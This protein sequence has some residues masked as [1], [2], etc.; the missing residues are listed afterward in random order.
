MVCPN[1]GKQCVDQA[2]KCPKCGAALTPQSQPINN[3]QPA[4]AGAYPAAKKKKLPVWAIVL[5]VIGA[6]VIV[7]VIG[8]L[9]NGGDSGKQ[10]TSPTAQDKVESKDDDKKDDEKVSSEESKPQESKEDYIKSAKEIA[11]KDLAREP[12]QYKGQRIKITVQIS[13][14]ISGGLFTSGGYRCYEDYDLGKGDTWLKK[15]WFVD[16]KLPEGASKILEDDVITFYGEFDGT[17]EMERALTGTKDE[18]PVLKAVYYDLV[19]E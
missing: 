6:I 8:N 19:S 4:P 14:I 13:Q 15:E 2:V 5:I 18:V 10:P 16:Y 12:D 9:A 17:T 3:Q 7:G 11:Y 1:C